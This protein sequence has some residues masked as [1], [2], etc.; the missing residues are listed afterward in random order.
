LS[1]YI[2]ELQKPIPEVE[3]IAILATG[4][5]SQA[6]RELITDELT[7]QVIKHIF[8]VIGLKCVSLSNNGRRPITMATKALYESYASMHYLCLKEYYF[9]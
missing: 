6:I 9:N 5:L 7:P 3:F 2:G 1:I 8:G 4:N